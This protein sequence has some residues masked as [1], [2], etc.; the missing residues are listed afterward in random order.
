[1]Q[2]EQLAAIETRDE[3][4]EAIHRRLTIDPAKLDHLHDETTWRMIAALHLHF[5]QR[6]PAR[7]PMFFEAVQ[8]LA[9]RIEQSPR[10]ASDYWS[11]VASLVQDMDDEQRRAFD[12]RCPVAAL[13]EHDD[14]DAWNAALSRLHAKARLSAD[15]DWQDYARTQL[16]P[17]CRRWPDPALTVATLVLGQLARHTGCHTNTALITDIADACLNAADYRSGSLAQWASDHI[18]V[19]SMFAK[20]PDDLSDLTTT[21][22]EVCQTLANSDRKLDESLL[23]SELRA[24]VEKVQA[25]MTEIEPARLFCLM[26]DVRRTIA[27]LPTAN[28]QPYFTDREI[29]LGVPGPVI[30]GLVADSS[31][32]QPVSSASNKRV[33]ANCTPTSSDSHPG[34]TEER[35]ASKALH[36]TTSPPKWIGHAAPA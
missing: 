3:L 28:A 22:A 33:V 31:E 13:P 34:K 32:K 8:E 21:V 9:V 12:Q 4:A 19:R 30:S 18:A 24:L 15:L 36:R 11:L 26:R 6:Q 35:R 10:V 14:P 23:A 29:L 17:A 7:L 1:M 16:L 25:L 27:G 20:E 2:L 5:Q